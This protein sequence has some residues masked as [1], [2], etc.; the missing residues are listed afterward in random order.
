MIRPVTLQERLLYHQ[1]HPLKLLTDISAAALGVYLIW[2]RALL[3]SLVVLFVPTTA[4][5]L[6]LLRR[7][8]LEPLRDS[9]LGRYVRAYM[10]RSVE[11]A[12]SAGMAVMIAGA[13]YRVG[14]VI[15]AGALIVLGAWLNGVIFPNPRG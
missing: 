15:A 13:W 6:L 12:R 8:N 3:P 2:Q 1:I 5:S 14:W 11:L 4:V 7:A 9:R 10:T